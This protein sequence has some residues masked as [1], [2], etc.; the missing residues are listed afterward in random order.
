MLYLSLVVGEAWRK[1]YLRNLED[2]NVLG[3][4][5]LSEGLQGVQINFEPWMEMSLAKRAIPCLKCIAE[6]GN[7]RMVSLEATYKVKLAVEED[8][9]VLRSMLNDRNRRI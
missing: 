1:Y 8:M 6:L 7:V 9:R 5:K 4:V 2:S 3:G